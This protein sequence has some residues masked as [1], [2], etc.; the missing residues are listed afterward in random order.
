MQISTDNQTWNTVKTTTDGQGGV[1]E[2][3]LSNLKVRYI[4]VN[5]TR[6]IAT[7]QSNFYGYSILELEAYGPVSTG[8]TS[9]EVNRISVYPNPAS[10]RVMIQGC[11]VVRVSI[12]SLQGK[13]LK[14]ANTSNFDISG[15]NSGLYLIS[16]TDKSGNKTTL[17]LQIR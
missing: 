17:K 6:K 8:I 16:V 5:C 12:Y 7:Y 11:E 9:P 4:K 14:T 2:I 10:D 13:E 3:A 15:L 1:V